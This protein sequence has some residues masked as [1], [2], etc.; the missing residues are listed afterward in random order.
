MTCLLTIRT[1]NAGHNSLLND[2]KD[3][4]DAAHR[5]GDLGLALRSYR[6]ALAQYDR[7][8]ATAA[9]VALRCRLSLALCMLKRGDARGAL[10]ECTTLLEARRPQASP[11]VTLSQF[12]FKTGSF[13]AQS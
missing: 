3:A 6:D 9:P 13:I 5:R 10:S 1:L 8:D 4:A 11:T 7:N 12:T 2:A